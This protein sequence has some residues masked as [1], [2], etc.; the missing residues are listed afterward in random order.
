MRQIMPG[1]TQDENP[2]RW[3]A[4]GAFELIEAGFDQ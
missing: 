2:G 4:T 1:R 3:R